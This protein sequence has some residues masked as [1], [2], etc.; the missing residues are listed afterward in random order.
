MPYLASDLVTSSLRLLKAIASGETPST[1]EALDGFNALIQLLANWSA[2]E[3]TVFATQTLVLSTANGTASYTTAAV[4]PSTRPVKILSADISTGGMTFPV[5]VVGPAQWAATPDKL[6]SSPRPRFLYCDYAYPTPAFQVAPK[7]NGIF[8]INLYC[9]TDLATL[10]SQGTTF[11]MPEGYLKAIRY[12][13][14]C[15]LAP[16]YGT[17]PAHLASIQKIAA[18]SKALLI[19]MNASN[20]AGKSELALPPVPAELTA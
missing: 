12:N 13:L 10:A 11:D 20:R 4:T 6:D 19:E 2:N 14:A 18:E 9:I 5:E 16:E 7:P 17:P 3:L 15:D 8:N 1:D